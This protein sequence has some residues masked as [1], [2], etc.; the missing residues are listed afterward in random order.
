MSKKPKFMHYPSEFGAWVA[1][2]GRN[3]K[4]KKKAGI[5]DEILNDRY[6]QIGQIRRAQNDLDRHV[7]WQ[8]VYDPAFDIEY[9]RAISELK[10]SE[11]QAHKYA[12]QQAE[13]AVVKNFEGEVSTTRAVRNAI[14][15]LN[16]ESE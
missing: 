2:L 16:A 11:K 14:N 6:R 3:L 8:E 9:K 4:A 10:M 5:K 7:K 15:G 1:A 12:R 13:R